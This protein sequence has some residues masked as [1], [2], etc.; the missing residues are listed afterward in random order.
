MLVLAPLWYQVALRDETGRVHGRG[1]DR[2]VSYGSP[3]TIYSNFGVGGRFLVP[4]GEAL[5]VTCCTPG[6]LASP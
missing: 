3:I 6:A 2:L 4:A 1:K 5:D